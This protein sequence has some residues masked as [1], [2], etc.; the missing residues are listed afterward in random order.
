MCIKKKKETQGPPTTP[1]LRKKSRKT[2]SRFHKFIHYGLKQKLRCWVLAPL[3]I[4]IIITVAISFA[5][6]LYVEPY[7]FS[8][9]GDEIVNNQ[10]NSMQSISGSISD[11]MREY[12]QR[13]YMHFYIK[14]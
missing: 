13:V 8:V 11:Y 14:C 2:T 4:G 12:I 9:T 5:I 10:L 7:W 3:F 6:V 1:E